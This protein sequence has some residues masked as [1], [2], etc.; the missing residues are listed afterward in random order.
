MNNN[1]E[2]INYLPSSR[3]VLSL[4]LA[5]WLAV[6]GFCLELSVGVFLLVEP[7]VSYESTGTPAVVFLFW[8]IFAIVGIVI[9]ASV[10][11]WLRMLHFLAAYDRSSAVQRGCWFLVVLVGLAWGAALYY[12]VVY[13]RLVER[14]FNQRGELVNKTDLAKGIQG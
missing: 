13:Q 14:T 1:E 10:Y 8:T 3:T 2:G 11:L 6:L 9:L 4:R 5:F 7:G 12:I